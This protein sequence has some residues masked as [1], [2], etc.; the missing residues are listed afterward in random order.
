MTIDELISTGEQFEIK[1]ET[2]HCLR[3]AF[4]MTQIVSGYSYLPNADKFATWLQNCVR[5]LAQNFPGDV[6]IDDFKNVVVE[7]ITQGQIYKLVG[8]LKSLKEIPVIYEAHASSQQTTNITVTQTQSQSQTLSCILNLLKDE[9]KGKE[10]K[11]IED[12]L[13]SDDTKENKKQ[14]IISKLKSFGENVAAGI[15]ASILTNGI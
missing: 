7:N 4:G 8:I 10:Y 1:R 14:S 13:A 15:V 9:I 6:S 5:F 3:G 2:S 12:I 11:E